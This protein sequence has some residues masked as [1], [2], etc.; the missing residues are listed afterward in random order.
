MNENRVKIDSDN[1]AIQRIEEKCINCGACLNVC[2]DEVGIE[3]KCRIEDGNSCVNC[4][5]CILACPMGALREKYDY[6]TV[7]NLLNDTDK[8]VSISV[9]PAVRVA[10]GEEFGLEFGTSLEGA[11]PSVLRAMGFSYVFDVTFGADVTIMEEAMELLSRIKNGGPLPMFT[12]CC[13]AWVK[14]AK[15]KHPELVQ[16]LSTAKSPIG[17]MSTLIKTYFKEMNGID[18]DIISVVVAPCTAK[19][20]EIIGEDTDYVIT[21]RELAYMIKES[22]VTLDPSKVSS[23]DILLGHGSKAGLLFGRS[24]GVMESALA[25]VNHFATGKNINEGEY[26]VEITGTINEEKFKI[27]DKILNVAVIYG[28]KNLESILPDKDKYDFIEVMNCKGGCVGGGGQPIGTRQDAEVRRSKRSEG[29]NLQNNAYMYPYENES[30]GEL[31]RSY[32][33]AP[34][35]DLSKKLLHIDRNLKQ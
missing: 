13:P 32:L 2:C 23:F 21:T 31:Y 12:S 4:G 11:L 22:G 20:W 19:K 7:M 1:P 28:L 3:R 18:D 8:K 17:M 9:A 27:G 5:Q 25:T 16:N 24:G 29:I 33:L 15:M 26:R 6:R 35:S 10:L 14:Y 34:Y 30:I